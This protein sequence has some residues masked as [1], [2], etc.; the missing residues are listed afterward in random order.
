V[1]WS[2]DGI[3]LASCGDDGSVR[4]WEAS[5]G[6]VRAA[7]QGHDLVAMRVAWRSDGT[8][9]ASGGGGRQGGELFVWDV[10]HGT[11]QR[12]LPV[13]RLRGCFLRLSPLR[14]GTTVLQ[15]FWVNSQ[16]TSDT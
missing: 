7:L 4:L 5:D 16:P 14:V 9:L 6:M 15:L 11:R 8:W 2:P 12:I 3:H 13:Q 1:A 10:K